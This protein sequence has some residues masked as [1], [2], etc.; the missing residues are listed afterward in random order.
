MANIILQNNQNNPLSYLIAV[1]ICSLIW[2]GVFFI[3]SRIIY[4]DEKKFKYQQIEFIA[5]NFYKSTSP[6]IKKIINN[7][8]TYASQKKIE[9]E[10]VQ[11][12]KKVDSFWISEIT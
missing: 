5:N 6:S 1:I 9:E 8:N 2:G 4:L 11:K 7:K 12:L 10:E 3:Y